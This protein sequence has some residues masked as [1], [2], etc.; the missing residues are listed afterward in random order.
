ME[1]QFSLL[2]R[3]FDC[4][5]LA[6]MQIMGLAVNVTALDRTASLYYS[7]YHNFSNC[8]IVSQAIELRVCV[9]AQLFIVLEFNFLEVL[10][11]LGHK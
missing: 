5:R 8:F 11:S 10:Y 1:T 7:N 2:T 6:V 9:A 4:A 3:V